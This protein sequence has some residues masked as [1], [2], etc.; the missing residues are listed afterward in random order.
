[1]KWYRGE[2][3][4]KPKKG[5]KRVRYGYDSHNDLYVL[6]I[7]SAQTDDSARYTVRL[8]NQHGSARCTVTL[9]VSELGKVT[10]E[11][12]LIL[13]AEERLGKDEQSAELTLS[14]KTDSKAEVT[15]GAAIPAT[16][17]DEG[18]GKEKGRREM[19]V[20]EGGFEVVTRREEERVVMEGKGKTMRTITL[21][22][23]SGDSRRTNQSTTEE[24]VES[25]MESGGTVVESPGGEGAPVFVV[26]PKPAAVLSGE[27]VE[28]KCQVTG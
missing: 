4:I 7:Q 25:G 11:S 28:L 6:Q 26:K 18:E 20:E 21:E 14:G 10:E 3:R 23:S 24:S 12:S 13:K 17:Q 1:M 15:V 16:K 22:E 5:D 2:E 27:V 8:S 9:K 19:L